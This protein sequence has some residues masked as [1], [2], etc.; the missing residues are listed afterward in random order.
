MNKKISMFIVLLVLLIFQGLAFD[1]VRSISGNDIT[2]TINPVGGAGVFTISETLQGVTVVTSSLSP[3]CGYDGKIL[4]CNYDKSVQGT[5]IYKTQ[6]SGSVSGVMSGIDSTTKKY[7]TKSIT[8][9][10]AI[11]KTIAPCVPSWVEGSWSTCVNGQQTRTVT[12][13]NNCSP[14]PTNKPATSKTC[15]VTPSSSDCID[16]CEAEE[17]ACLNEGYDEAQCTPTYNSCAAACPVGGNLASPTLVCT[18]SDTIAV[19]DAK[20]GLSYP[21]SYKY[22]NLND[23]G[24]VTFKDA[25]GV[26]VGAAEPDSCDPVTGKVVERF[27]DD[28]GNLAKE[29]IACPQGKLCM[30]GAC[31][32]SDTGVGGELQVTAADQQE[33]DLFKRIHDALEKNS[34]SP[35]KQ[36]SSVAGVF[37]CYFKSDCDLATYQVK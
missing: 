33:A 5:I 20:D 32:S 18:D 15:T 26:V 30:G 34:G 10:S 28:K 2:L 19:N 17:Q 31:V 29:E 36:I 16:Q 4:S 8:G 14:V 22:I 11:P 6:G 7:S 23:K 3:D 37:Q 21:T 27:C 35:L 13:S 25:T 9:D 12:D 1:V 24:L